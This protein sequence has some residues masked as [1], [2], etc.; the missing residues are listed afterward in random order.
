[1]EQHF[2][3]KNKCCFYKKQHYKDDKKYEYNKRRY[4]AG[5][6][7]HD[8]C[9]NKIL[10]IQSRGRLWGPPKGT[11]NPNEDVKCCAIREV[12]EETGIQIKKHELE[13]RTNIKKTSTYFYNERNEC[14]IFIQNN[15]TDNDA[16]GIG[17]FKI[18]CL[19]DLIQNKKIQVT[20]H[21]KILVKKYFN[22]KI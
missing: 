7:I 12:L 2:F 4:K 3:C 6:F 9:T 21:T 8:P 17:W 5:V 18:N 11:I 16:N 15:I 10:L 13:D 19:F 1:M 14:E 20:Y 22:K